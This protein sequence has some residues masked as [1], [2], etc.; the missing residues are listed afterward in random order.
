M[1]GASN[2]RFQPRSAVA[3]SAKITT[4]S[5]IFAVER[6][7]RLHLTMTSISRR[8]QGGRRQA[9]E[10]ADGTYRRQGQA[11]DGPCEIAAAPPAIV[12]DGALEADDTRPA[13]PLR[14]IDDDQVIHYFRRN[15]GLSDNR[16]GGTLR[17]GQFPG[18]SR[19]QPSEKQRLRDQEVRCFRHRVWFP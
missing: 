13:L 11:D 19:V 4:V 14:G 12:A 17:I 2:A 15:V 3:L 6:N 5:V 10:A 7:H 1:F 9:A 18:L 8:L 16:P